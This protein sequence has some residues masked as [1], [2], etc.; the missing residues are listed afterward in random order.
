M[1]DDT[2]RSPVAQ[3]F[4]R[5]IINMVINS[6]LY[7]GILGC[8][9]GIGQIMIRRLEGKGISNLIVFDPR[10]FE[11]LYFEKSFKN[12]LLFLVIWFIMEFCEPFD[13]GLEL[14]RYLPPPKAKTGK[15]RANDRK[16]A[17]GILYALVIGCKWMNMPTRYGSYKL[18]L[19]G[20]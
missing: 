6:A 3:V 15:S 1:F 20:A 18:L 14:I 9:Q 10:I 8:F 17:N 5:R 19:K 12:C 7:R 16:T 4:R 13:S 2:H 11:I